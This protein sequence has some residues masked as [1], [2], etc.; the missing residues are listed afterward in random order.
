VDRLFAGEDTRTMA[1]RWILENVPSGEAVALQS[2]SVVLPHSSE[3]LRESLAA[4]GA[5]GELDGR[6]KYFHLAELAERSNP[7]YRLFFLG[8][9]DEKDRIYF[10]YQ[11]GVDRLLERGVRLVVL[12]HAPVEP[13]PAVTTFFA[14]IT[15]R[16]KRILRI[17][18]FVEDGRWKPYLD[19]EDWPVARG[20]SAKGPVVE[21]WALADP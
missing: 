20:L 9:G 4:R 8:R 7:S 2:F 10:D 21:L 11:G 1:R 19:N 5:L 18:P 12:R 16:G 14:E 3:S 17:S 15:R 6:G 13:P